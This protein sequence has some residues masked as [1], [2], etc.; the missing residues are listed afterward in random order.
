MAGGFWA[1]HLIDTYSLSI[2][3]SVRL[4]WAIYRRKVGGFVVVLIMEVFTQA[5]GA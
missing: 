5:S 2:E 1:H 4:L 3:E